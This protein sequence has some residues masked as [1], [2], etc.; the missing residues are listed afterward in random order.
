MLGAPA[1]GRW[2]GGALRLCGLRVGAGGAGAT[3][4]LPPFFLRCAG[5]A[6][7]LT[8]P[9]AHLLCICTGCRPARWA[10]ARADPLSKKEAGA[11]PR[12]WHKSYH[13]CLLG[14]RGPPVRLRASELPL[15]VSDD[16]CFFMFSPSCHTRMHPPH[17]DSENRGRTAAARGSRIDV[18]SIMF[19]HLRPRPTDRPLPAA[20]HGQPP[21]ISD[22]G[23]S[24][25][26]RMQ[27][28]SRLKP[29]HA[30]HPTM[31][32]N[33]AARRGAGELCRPPVAIQRSRHSP[34]R[35]RDL[36]HLDQTDLRRVGVRLP[37]QPH[38]LAWHTDT[39]RDHR[40]ILRTHPR[41][42]RNTLHRCARRDQRHDDLCG[43]GK[44]LCHGAVRDAASRL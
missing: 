15:P 4:A 8:G 28:P 11:A 5:G 14:V 33:L 13:N 10:W 16:A 20:H 29:G 27:R 18:V 39:H 25:L 24:L 7:P 9:A 12:P 34:A 30:K 23:T 22:T 21:C 6:G 38:W 19:I 44:L 31:R 36:L 35:R 32:Q 1:R 3:P 37:V 2:L 43:R 40:R 26:S 17:C 41:R 42:N